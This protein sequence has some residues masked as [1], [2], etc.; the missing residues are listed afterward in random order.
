MMELCRSTPLDVSASSSGRAMIDF[1]VKSRQRRS[2]LGAV[3]AA[4]LVVTAAAVTVS[5]GHLEIGPVPPPPHGA[6]K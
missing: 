2:V 1:D 4:M 5:C 6:Y 3:L